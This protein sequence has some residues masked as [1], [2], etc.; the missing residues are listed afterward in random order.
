[1]GIKSKI[2]KFWN[3][4]EA[5]SKELQSDNISNKMIDE[6]NGKVLNLGDFSWEVREGINKQ[7]LFIV[8]PGGDPQLLLKTKEIIELAP[9]SLPEWEFLDCKPPKD[10]DY[11]LSI[12]ESGVKKMV[13]ASNWEYVL[14]RF[15]DNSFDIVIKT[16][17]LRFSNF[18]EKY[19]IV[20]TVLESILG[21]RLSLSLIKNVEI[22]DEFN[23]VD[24]K[25]R[26]SIKDLQ[27]HIL[28]N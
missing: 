25:N 15:Q 6:L 24:I 1:M 20:D 9:Q 21:E 13:D 26:G 23:E 7:N 16:S 18:D 19:N 27:N 3:W 5:N 4:F 28:E 14:F 17:G 12:D 2:K 22:V 11:Q 10:W 8:S